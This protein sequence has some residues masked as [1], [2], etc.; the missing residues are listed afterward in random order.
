MSDRSSP[1]SKTI[2]VYSHDHATYR[3]F[4]TSWNPSDLPS[5]LRLSPK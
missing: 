2:M 4:A 1:D 3:S 5:K